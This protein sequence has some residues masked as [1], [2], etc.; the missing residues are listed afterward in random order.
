MPL[1]TCKI[2]GKSYT[3]RDALTRHMNVKH[4]KYAKE[5]YD[6]DDEDDLDDKDDVKDVDNGQLDNDNVK[7]T[8]RYDVFGQLRCH[9]CGQ[10]FGSQE[11]LEHHLR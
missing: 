8:K 7:K 10:I 3:R 5:G 1:Y 4:P 2:C 11:L 6:S 9:K